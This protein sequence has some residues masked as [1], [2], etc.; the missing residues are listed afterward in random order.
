MTNVTVTD[1][2]LSDTISCDAAQPS[3]LGPGESM[4]CTGSYTAT[5]A[6][7]DSN[8]G[9]DGDIDNTATADSN[10]TNSVDDSVGVAVLKGR[11]MS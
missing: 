10:E 4:T 7:I 6:D 3:E 1:E 9:G 5:Q 2:L 8:G 11:I